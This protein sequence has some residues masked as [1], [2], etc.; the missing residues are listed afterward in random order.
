[1]NHDRCSLGLNHKTLLRI[2]IDAEYLDW[3][4]V[5]RRRRSETVAFGGELMAVKLCLDKPTAVW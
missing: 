2:N 1:M 4:S 3:F 5:K